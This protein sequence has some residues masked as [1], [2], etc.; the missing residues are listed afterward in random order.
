MNGLSK[1]RRV[2]EWCAREDSNLHP[3]RDQ[4][5]SLERLPFRHAR[6]HERP[7]GTMPSPIFLHLNNQ[8]NKLKHSIVGGQ[9]VPSTF[10]SESR[11]RLFS[12]DVPMEMRIHSGS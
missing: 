9:F 10:L 7:A 1:P 8:L 5:L 11:Q 6:V 2:V 3:F 4:I 12:F